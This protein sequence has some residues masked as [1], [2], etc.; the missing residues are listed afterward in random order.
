LRIKTGKW[1][2]LIE[3]VGID[4]M[5]TVI[6]FLACLSLYPSLNAGNK[7][8]GIIDVIAGAVTISAIVIEAV[9]D[10]QLS[11]FTLYKHQAGEIMAKGLWA[12]S[13][14]P[15]YF[16][17][18]MFWWGIFVF[19]LAADTGYWWTII[20]PLSVTILFITVSI[21]LMEKRNLQRRPDYSDI[22]TK[23][24]VLFPWFPKTS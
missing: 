14:H 20:G 18:I 19:G 21:P 3:L 6:V 4:L 8:L 17:E 5:P 2:W 24:P 22:R 12:Y 13:R 1:F 9:A 16:G 10:A 11:K 15:N 7:S 23:I